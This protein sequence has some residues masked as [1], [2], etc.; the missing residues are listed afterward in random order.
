MFA[1]YGLFLVKIFTLSQFQFA[2]FL[3]ANRCIL[4]LL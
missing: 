2:H 1:L 3:F 4:L